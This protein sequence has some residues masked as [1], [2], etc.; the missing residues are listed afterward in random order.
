MHVP[1]HGTAL[2]NVLFLVPSPLGTNSGSESAHMTEQLPVAA[3]SM[4]AAPP[5]LLG[6]AVSRRWHKPCVSGA[7]LPE[8][9]RSAGDAGATAAAQGIQR[10][11]TAAG[12][13]SAIH[14]PFY[15]YLSALPT[16]SISAATL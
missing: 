3:V 1:Q 7:A 6:A 13:V 14:W 12:A 9:G 11:E 8:R 5:Q 2:R 16:D 10:Q 4:L 15:C